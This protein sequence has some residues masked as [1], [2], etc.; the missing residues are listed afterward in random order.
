MV[1]YRLR[2]AMFRT[3]VLLVSIVGVVSLGS[4]SE[5]FGGVTAVSEKAPPEWRTD[6]TGIYAPE[7]DIDKEYFLKANDAIYFLYLAQKAFGSQ[8]YRNAL[9]YAGKS[10]SIET[11]AEAF[12]LL[13]SAHY[14]LGDMEKAKQNWLKAIEL[15]KEI[16]VPDYIVPLVTDTLLRGR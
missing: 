3:A 16:P 11:S 14:F 2:T 8:E 13:G 7:S 1:P 9:L 10:L 5:S 15:E 6:T 4:A 12:G